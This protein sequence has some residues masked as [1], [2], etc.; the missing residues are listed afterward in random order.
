LSVTGFG[1]DGESCV[2]AFVIGDAGDALPNLGHQGRSEYPVKTLR[3]GGKFL[4]KEVEA[5][6]PLRRNFAGSRQFAEDQR[7]TL[8]GLLEASYFHDW[9]NDPFS[10]GAHSYGKVGSNGAQKTLAEPADN[11]LL[12]A[13]EAT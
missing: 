8:Y 7:R 1:S 12:F 5:L 3:E 2:D 9:Q 6:A 13:N 4:T 11:T 10:R